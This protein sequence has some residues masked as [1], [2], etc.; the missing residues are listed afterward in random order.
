LRRVSLGAFCPPMQRSTAKVNFVFPKKL[1][2]D[3]IVL[4]SARLQVLRKLRLYYLQAQFLDFQGESVGV[5]AMR[6]K[7]RL[8]EKDLKWCL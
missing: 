2:T 5:K 7:Q 8:G 1:E 4:F 6:R 3:I